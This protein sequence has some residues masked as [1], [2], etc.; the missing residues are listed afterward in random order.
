MPAECYHFEH[1]G[2]TVDDLEV[3]VAWYEAQFGFTVVKRFEKPSLQIIGA[4][5]KLHDS[6][7]EIL[8]HKGMVQE[9]SVLSSLIADLTKKGNYH[10]AFSVDDIYSSYERLKADGAELLTEIME[11]RYF[12]CR[13]REGRLLE[14]RMTIRS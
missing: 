10:F 8:E 14:I 4:L 3:T 12:F 6:F 9:E 5:L 13:D 7:L 2:I 11:S 1:I